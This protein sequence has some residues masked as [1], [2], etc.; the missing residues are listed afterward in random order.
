MVEQQKELICPNCGP[1][2]KTH[3]GQGDKVI[4]ETCGGTFIFVAGEAKLK[5]FGELDKIKADVEELK[6]RLPASSPAAP[7]A[8][9]PDKDPESEDD[10]EDDNDE[11][12][13]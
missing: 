10:P 2:T 11:D 4:C 1:G 3:A 12:L 9:E 8:A 5:D 6:K 13:W 7:P